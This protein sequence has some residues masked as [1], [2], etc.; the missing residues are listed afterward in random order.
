MLAH[1][2]SIHVSNTPSIGKDVDGR[3]GPT[4]TAECVCQASGSNVI[5]SPLMQ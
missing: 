3:D 2:T 4:M 1:V 5:A